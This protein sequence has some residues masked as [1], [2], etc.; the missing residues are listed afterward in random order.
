M[1]FL[2]HYLFVTAIIFAVSFLLHRSSRHRRL[3]L[4]PGNLGLPLVGETLQLIAAYKTEN[5]EPFI[6]ERVRRYGSIFTTHV[7]GEPTVFSAEPETNR[8]ILQNEGKLFECSYPG[9]ISNLLGKHSLLLMKGSLHKKMHSLT[10][11]FANSSIIK[12]HL[13]VDI[14][15]LIRLNLDSWTDRVFLMEEAKKIT[16]ELTVKQLMSYD[17]GEWSESLRKEYLLVIEGFFTVPLPLFSTTYR[18]AIRARTK[19]AEALSLIVTERRKEY[20][21]GTKK[22]DMLAALLAGDDKFS[23]EQIVDFLV[24][25]LVAGYETTST[26]MTLAVKFLTETPLALAQLKEEHE[27][28]RAK[29]SESEALQWSDY[30]SMPFTQC[31]VNE[32]LRVANIISGV[33]R[34]AMTDIN[35]KGYTIPKGWRVFASFRAVHLDHNQFKDARTF[36]PWR[37]QSKSGISCPGNVFTPFGGGPRLC[38]GYELARV[39]LS[40][41]LHHLVTRF[42][43]EPAEEDKLVFFPTTRTQ[44]RYP[45][46]SNSG[47]SCPGHVFTPFG[48]GPRLCPGYELARVELSVF[49]H[50]LVTRFSWEPAEEDKLVFFPT[51]R[52]QKRY[53]INVRRR[54]GSF[55]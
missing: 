40:V 7:F 25:L 54:N 5:P 14:D 34:R 45:I 26:I 12:D 6:D 10:M 37:W 42:S 30:K 28:I 39:E 17:P 27:G 36:N 44:K 31:V 22:N 52:T 53:P 15:R 33:F 8:F 24:A 38:P 55:S 13:L 43:W 11:S 18:R 51:T 19:V 21:R 1:A 29:K 41:F 23:D 9:S 2:L 16:F 32:T 48:G 35:I 20:E 49:L 46:N 3:R 50:H 47:I 4:P